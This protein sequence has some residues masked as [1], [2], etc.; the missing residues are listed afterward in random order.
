MT[1]NNKNC[2]YMVVKR[3]LSVVPRQ[4]DPKLGVDFRSRMAE[5]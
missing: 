3:N 2:I 1:K 4:R 5:N